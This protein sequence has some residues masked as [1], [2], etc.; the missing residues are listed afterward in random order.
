MSAVSRGTAHGTTLKAASTA[1]TRVAASM[2]RNTTETIGMIERMPA[3]FSAVSPSISGAGRRAEWA[4][5]ACGAPPRARW[6]PVPAPGAAGRRGPVAACVR[7][8]SR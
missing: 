6:L 1:V 2:P 4:L 7:A 5:P 3:I 8:V